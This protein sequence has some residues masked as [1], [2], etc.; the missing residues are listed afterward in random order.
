MTRTIWTPNEPVEWKP[1]CPADYIDP[2]GH[3]F[4]PSSRRG[5]LNI[6]VLP[7]LTGKPWDEIAMGYVQGLR[8]SS[9]RIVKNEETTDAQTWRVT[10]YIDDQHRIKQI[11]QEV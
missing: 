2:C 5:Y 10:V 1:T 3:E 4:I 9:L 7:N 11:H 6:P 8:P